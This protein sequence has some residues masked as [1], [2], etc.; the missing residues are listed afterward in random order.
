MM[1]ARLTR[2]SDATLNAF[3][4]LRGTVPDDTL[5]SQTERCLKNVMEASAPAACY[6]VLPFTV[7][8]DGIRPNGTDLLLS[9]T[10]IATHLLGCTA[11][12]LMAAT[13]GTG[14]E[15]LLLRSEAADVGDA[16]IT[17]ACAGAVIETVCDNLENDLRAFFSK[18]GLHLTGRFSP[19]YGD[20][21][22][23]LQGSILSVLDARRAIGLTVT[24][25]GIMVPRKSVTAILGIS[26]VP[27][28]GHRAGCNTCAIRSGCTHRKEGHTC[29][30]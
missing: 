9:G 23:D 10:D 20:L 8:P 2:P 27:T 4:G 15:R 30:S 25:S 18:R 16:L 21:P 6:R 28:E 11:L 19:G 24:P 3:L 13:I 12:L 5:R 1:T 22:L 26:P 7:L 17:D 29:E 14:V